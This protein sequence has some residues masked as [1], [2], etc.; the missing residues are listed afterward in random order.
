MIWNLKLLSDVEMDEEELN[1]HV[2]RIQEDKKDQVNLLDTV[3]EPKISKM[4]EALV[5]EKTGVMGNCRCLGCSA[6]NDIHKDFPIFR[7]GATIFRLIQNNEE[8]Y[9]ESVVHQHLQCYYTFSRVKKNTKGS[10]NWK[11]H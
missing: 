5:A 9:V 6:I 1:M 7:L 4:V 11:C 10:E 2:A 3:W 8:R